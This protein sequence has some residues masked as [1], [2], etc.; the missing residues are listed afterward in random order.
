MFSSS[1]NFGSGDFDE[2]DTTATL[3]STPQRDV[4]QRVDMLPPHAL[5]DD[6]I[7]TTPQPE[8]RTEPAR[9][10]ETSAEPEE[11]DPNRPKRSGWWQRRSFFG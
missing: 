3:D 9:S 8:R 5:A 10:A 6:E 1:G 7:D 4:P 2:V 11:D